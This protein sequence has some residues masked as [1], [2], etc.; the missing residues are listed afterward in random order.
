MKKM[1]LLFSHT[2]SDIQKH[3][4]ITQL[5]VEE[6]IYLSAELQTIWSD[7]APDIKDINAQ[8][9]PIKR[10]ISLH[11]S[12]NDI[13]LIQGDF[14]AT[15]MMVNFCKNRDIE[16]FYSTTKRVLSE[17]QNDEYQRVKESIFEH[18]R[19]RKYA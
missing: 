2:L 4:A 8:L 3:E 19:F 13:A 18:R 14:G 11:V 16:C 12:S 6:F 10:F 15:Y 5:H 9:E 17:Y 1:I 7:I